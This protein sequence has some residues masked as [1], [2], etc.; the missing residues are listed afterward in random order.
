MSGIIINPY[1]FATGS[2]F[3]STKS[4][5]FDGVDGVIDLGADSTVG[6]AGITTIS[7]WIKGGVA[8]TLGISD[9]VLGADSYN[10]WTFYEGYGADLIFRN[11]NGVGYI[12]MTDVFDDNWHNIVILRNPSGGDG[13]LRIYKDGANETNVTLDWRFGS[14]GLYN[15]PLRYI[16]RTYS[17]SYN[18]LDGNMDEVA[19]WNSELS[20]ADIATIYNSGAPGDLTSLSP[21]A[22]YRMGENSTFSSPQILMPENTNKDKVSNY[23]MAFDGIDDY[24]E[25]PT[26]SAYTVTSLSMWVKT[27]KVF[28]VNVRDSLASNNNYNQGRDFFIGDTPTS[29]NDAYIG[30]TAGASIYGKTSATGGIPIN[31]G[32]WHFLV[33]TYD[34]TAGTSAA[35]NMYVDGANQYSQAANTSW[36]TREVKYQY[37]GKLISATNNFT[38]NIDEISIFNTILSPSDITTLYN[39]GI[40]T[41]LTSLSPVSWW[42]MG[43]E[44][45]FNST[46]W[47]LPN[48]AQDVYSRYS[49]DF[50]GTDDYVDLGSPSA[51][52]LT[53]EMTASLWIKPSLISTGIRFVVGQSNA[54]AGNYQ[55]F[56]DINRVAGKLTLGTL[57]TTVLTSNTTMVVDTW[58]HVAFTRTGSAGNWDYVIYLNGIPDG[59]T[60]GSATNPGTQERTCIGRIGDY[61]GLYFPGSIDEVAIWNS[62]LTAGDITTIYNSGT[63]NDLTSLSPVAWWRM[64]EDATFSTNWTIPDKVGSNTGTSVNMTNDDLSGDAPGVTGNGVSA[65][66]TIEDRTGDAPDSSNNALSYNMDAADIVEDTP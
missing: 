12:I 35:I 33:W 5:N 16:G 1:L 41:D 36:W 31:D 21:Q 64:G 22:W 42:R 39:S 3:S 14:G 26:T 23:S 62:G 53:A 18:G 8:S 40:P 28:G 37:F 7:F 45:V 38:G 6:N 29:T 44:A 47:L 54:G 17:L 2:A 60:I 34:S 24:I 19:V 20:P 11:G 13:T 4:L 58:Y 51:L 63:P 32:N 50:D 56:I 25:I 10:N 55:W 43:E 65:N 52:N 15:G 61:N 27:S 66:M 48:K 49:L 46:N 30:M 57:N 59:T 9:L